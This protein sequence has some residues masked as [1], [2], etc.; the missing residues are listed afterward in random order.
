E[1]HDRDASFPFE[2]FE[3]LR[4]A[5]LLNL[6]VPVEEGGDG[7]GLRVRTQVLRAVATGDP[8]TALVLAMQYNQHA[9]LARNRRWPDEVYRRVVTDSLQGI[10]LLNSLRVEPELGTPAR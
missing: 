7:Q 5:G 3:D 6:G 1:Q 8:S 10:A 4:K 2:N 9:S